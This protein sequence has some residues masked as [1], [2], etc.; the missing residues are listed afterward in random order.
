[1][2]SMRKANDVEKKVQIE[3]LE[4]EISAKYWDHLDALKERRS[5]VLAALQY[6]G[7]AAAAAAAGG[8]LLR[9]ADKENPS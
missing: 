5:T 3:E 2:R 1:M 7:C 4:K 8:A 9:F 6:A